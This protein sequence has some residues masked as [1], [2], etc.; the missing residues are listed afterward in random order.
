[1]KRFTGAREFGSRTATRSQ[2]A[3]TAVHSPGFHTS[4][5]G[6]QA[7]TSARAAAF[8]ARG[9]SGVAHAPAGENMP[10]F[11]SVVSDLVEYW[12]ATAGY[13][14]VGGAVDTWTGQYAGNVLTAGGATHRPLYEASAINGLPALTGDGTDDYMS[15]TLSS[16]ILVG[17]RPYVWCVVEVVAY[18]DANQKQYL[19]LGTGA[20]TGRLT[21]NARSSTWYDFAAGAN[22]GFTT[23]GGAVSAGSAQLVEG[24]LTGTGTLVLNGTGYDAT[25]DPGALIVECSTVRAFWNPALAAVN[26]A[27]ARIAMI[28][29]SRSQPTTDQKQAA[30]DWIAALWGVP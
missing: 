15:C 23:T 29:I 26:A 13:A 22:G 8:T 9:A 28:A 1:M 4:T 20:G 2:Q 5:R 10:G 24:G 17:E 3:R 30:R 6:L 21:L 19:T 12:D 14:L 18:S 16:P 27:N 7:R 25:S 11:P